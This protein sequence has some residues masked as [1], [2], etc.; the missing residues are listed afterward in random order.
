MNKGR[1]GTPANSLPVDR[2]PLLRLPGTVVL[3]APLVTG[4]VPDR[5]VDRLHH[6]PPVTDDETVGAVL[7]VNVC[8][9]SAPLQEGIVATGQTGQVRFRQAP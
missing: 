6:D 7:H 1:S 8:R 5:V 3:D 4:P 2:C 9:L